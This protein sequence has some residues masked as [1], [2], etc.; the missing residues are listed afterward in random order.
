MTG[1]S[2]DETVVRSAALG[3]DCPVTLYRPARF[4]RGRAYPL[5]VVHDGG[6]YLHRAAMGALLDT[7]IERRAVA[8][9]VA[10]FLNPGERLVEY[11]DARTH[12]RFLT[13]ELVPRLEADL[14]LVG[15]PAGR[16]LMGASFGAVASLAAA[17]RAP[18]VYGALILMSGSF[19][20]TEFDGAD[21][22]ED[23][24]FDPVVALVNRYR[25][26]PRRV[27]DRLYITCGSTEDLIGVNRAMVPVFRSTGMAVS[28]TEIPAGHGWDN[29]SA[30]LPGALRWFAPGH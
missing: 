25:R 29:W 6:D 19:V 5:L 23:P 15:S 27:A 16:G 8:E 24:V 17:W 9:L 14:P 3:R 7:L 13:H 22:G 28:F 12:A 21:H 26:A 20:F 2:L 30:A 4:R 18:A 10:A 11:A 1:G